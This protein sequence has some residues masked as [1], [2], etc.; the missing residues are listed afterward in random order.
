MDLGIFG[1][2]DINPAGGLGPPVG[3]R[4]EAPG[5]Q[6]RCYF[7]FDRETPKYPLWYTL[8]MGF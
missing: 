2:G 6:T 1:G 4:E 7:T 5:Y 3:S 8:K